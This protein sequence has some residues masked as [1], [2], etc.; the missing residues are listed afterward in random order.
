MT[1]KRHFTFLAFAAVPLL[2]ALQFPDRAENLRQIS[3]FFSK[4]FLSVSHSLSGSVM[5][6][7][8]SLTRFW[9]LYKNHDELVKRMEELERQLVEQEELKKENVRLRE[10]LDF[11]KEIPAKAVPARVIGRDL[12]P[13]RKTILID[14]GSKDGID[15]RMAVVSAQGLVGRIVDV[16]LW[17]ARAVLL[18]DPESR[19][20]VFFQGNR[21][22]GVAEGDGSLKL[23]V[24]HVDRQAAVS[25]GERV[26]SS[27]MGEVYPKGIPVGEVEMV[28]TEE[29]GLE[30]FAV[31]RPYVDFSRLEE[32]LCITLS[33]R[34]T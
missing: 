26:V 12:A 9:N 27:G 7:T 20:S 18:P 10:L 4:P 3:L 16:S 2:F 17:S 6:T 22:L 25:V 19:V 1:R 34:D 30:V 14:K 33:P 24:T 21:D 15:K 8:Q 13:W 29:G 28:G 23:R 32:V 11:K 5:K 31:V